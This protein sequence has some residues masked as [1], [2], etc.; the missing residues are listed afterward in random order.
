MSGG[1]GKRAAPEARR[2]D[3]EQRADAL[4]AGTSARTPASPKPKRIKSSKMSLTRSFARVLP[5]SG[6]EEGSRTP[7]TELLRRPPDESQALTGVGDRMDT[8]EQQ[9]EGAGASE[10]PVTPRDVRKTA[11]LCARAR[12]LGALPDVTPSVLA[13]RVNKA[14]IVNLQRPRAPS[15][16]AEAVRPGGQASPHDGTVRRHNSQVCFLACAALKAASRARVLRLDGDLSLAFAPRPCACVLQGST[17][18]SA[19][20]SVHSGEMGVRGVILP[21]WMTQRQRAGPAGDWQCV[22]PAAGLW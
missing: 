11:L 2:T 9:K 21:Q 14:V 6:D 10:D 15:R 8:D 5:R 22:R 16:P 13:C 20:S 3:E 17:G 1:S 18:S 19:A 12:A 7:A 4:V